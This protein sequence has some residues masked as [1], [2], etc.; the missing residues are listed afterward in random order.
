MP[1]EVAHTAEPA[2]LVQA[3]DVE[4]RDDATAFTAR[5]DHDSE[6][7]I[8]LGSWPSSFAELEQHA[9]PRRLSRR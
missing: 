5:I 6:G 8:R 2:E 7:Q 4:Q 3:N 9:L 1:H